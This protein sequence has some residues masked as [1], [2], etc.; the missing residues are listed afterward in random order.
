MELD[1]KVMS[2]NERFALHCPSS[3]ETMLIL[4]APESSLGGRG[5]DQDRQEH[6]LAFIQSCLFR[7][8]H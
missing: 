5:A 3:K 2:V 7:G 6:F 8:N 4:H 1:L